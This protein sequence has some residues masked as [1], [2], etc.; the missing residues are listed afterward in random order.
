M[1]AQWLDWASNCLVSQQR[2]KASGVI[3]GLQIL[4]ASQKNLRFTAINT[5][6]QSAN[7]LHLIG[8]EVV[9]N[10]IDFVAEEEPNKQKHWLNTELMT[11]L[12][13]KPTNQTFPRLKIKQNPTHQWRDSSGN[14]SADT[15]AYSVRYSV[16]RCSDSAVNAVGSP[17]HYPSLPFLRS[18]PNS[19]SMDP[20]NH[21][22]YDILFKEFANSNW[23]SEKSIFHFCDEFI[24]FWNRIRIFHCSQC[25]GSSSR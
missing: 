4:R 17:Q 6:R 13:L 16:Y 22:C 3:V 1:G 19:E 2:N 25:S 9:P 12:T 18:K 11:F 10:R 21:F 7:D 14:T 8:S 20:N 15:Y 23:M 5:L 24:S